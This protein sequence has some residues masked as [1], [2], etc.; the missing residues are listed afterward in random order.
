MAARPAIHVLATTFDATRTALSAAIPLAKGSGARLVVLVPK[1]VSYAVPLDPTL[2]CTDFTV[3]RYRDVIRDYD[4]DARIQLCLCRR[5]I[6]VVRSL[7]PRNATVVIGGR[8]RAWLPTEETRLIR[9]LTSLGYH[10]VF[11]PTPQRIAAEPVA[12]RASSEALP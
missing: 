4:G 3:R 11:V 2:E 5:V 1:V 8:A 10:V 7:L 6:D 12:L 9:H